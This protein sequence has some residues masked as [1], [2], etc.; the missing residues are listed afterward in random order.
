MKHRIVCAI[1]ALA[2][3]IG[4]YLHLQ[5]WRGGYRYAPVK[6]MFLVN[7][8]VSVVVAVALLVF[9]RK[10]SALGGLLLSL[11]TLAAFGLSRGPGLP[12]L[13][14]KFTEKGLN[15]HNVRFLGQPA[16]VTILSAEGLAVVLCAAL[17]LSLQS[18]TSKSKSKSAGWAPAGL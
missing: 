1:A 2:V 7:V 11:G 15:P 12:T 10:I 17:L 8:G 16:A 4:G 18:S 5:I 14:G 9:P 13:H 3:A 6:E